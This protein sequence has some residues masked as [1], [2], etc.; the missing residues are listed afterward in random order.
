MAVVQLVRWRCRSFS[1]LI[2]ISRA[3][4]L[5]ICVDERWR[6]LQRDLG[7]DIAALVKS[8][9]SFDPDKGWKQ[10]RPP[11]THRW[12][13]APPTGRAANS[14]LLYGSPLHHSGH[15]TL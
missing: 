15:R 4:A 7:E 3:A 13:V 11:R 10:V 14:T 1:V 9:T 12:Q 5:A 6:R 8:M 2:S